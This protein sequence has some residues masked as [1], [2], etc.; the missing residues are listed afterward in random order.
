MYFNTWIQ[1]IKVHHTYLDLDQDL[2]RLR[3]INT[4][5]AVTIV[6]FT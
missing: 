1:N 4:P 2:V 5:E 6:P 3:L